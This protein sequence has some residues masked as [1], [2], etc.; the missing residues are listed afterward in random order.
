VTRRTELGPRF[1]EGSRKLWLLVLA[2]GNPGARRALARKIETDDGTLHR[3]L[4]G[5]RRPSLE[6][7]GRLSR[8]GIK[9]ET[10]TIKPREPFTPTA[11]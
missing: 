5:D 8:L 4:W 6:L 2:A 10:W 7:A 9:P 11:E 1:S 3:L